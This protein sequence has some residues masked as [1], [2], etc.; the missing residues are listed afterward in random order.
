LMQCICISWKR[1][2]KWPL[3][4]VRLNGRCIGRVYCGILSQDARTEFFET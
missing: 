4:G 3:G 2:K 1:S